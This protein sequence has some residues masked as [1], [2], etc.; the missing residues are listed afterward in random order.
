MSIS[1]STQV[2]LHFAKAVRN[3]I[4]ENPVITKSLAELGLVNAKVTVIHQKGTDNRQVNVCFDLTEGDNIE[5]IARK[6]GI[7]VVPAVMQQLQKE[8]VAEK[9]ATEFFCVP[10][11]PDHQ[12]DAVVAIFSFG[13]NMKYT[14]ME[15]GSAI[16]P[17]PN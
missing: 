8:G 17:R 6:F 7:G 15:M 1:A 13:E 16:Q 10:Q 9:P 14:T 11:T 4:S 12:K 5:G 2:S 3:C